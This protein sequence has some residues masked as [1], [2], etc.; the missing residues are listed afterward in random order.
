MITSD[1]FTSWY[2]RKFKTA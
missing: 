2:S 1:L